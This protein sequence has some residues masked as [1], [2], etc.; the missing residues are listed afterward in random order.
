M[1]G[2]RN[3]TKSRIPSSKEP[4]FKL[5]HLTPSWRHACMHVQSSGVE[6]VFRGSGG[7]TIKEDAAQTDGETGKGEEARGRLGGG[8]TRK[9][10]CG[11]GSIHSK[12]NRRQKW[13]FFNFVVVLLVELAISRSIA[14]TEGGSRG[15]SRERVSF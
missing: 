7:S 11:E 13:I 9:N 15:R 8:R 4:F 6:Q 2:F 10:T 3:E 5:R 1:R 14:Q 12:E